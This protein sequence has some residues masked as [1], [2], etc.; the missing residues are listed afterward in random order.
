MRRFRKKRLCDVMQEDRSSGTDK[1]VSEFLAVVNGGAVTFGFPDPRVRAYRW[2][3]QH[4][5]LISV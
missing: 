4:L 1:G 3:V 2:S 5:S